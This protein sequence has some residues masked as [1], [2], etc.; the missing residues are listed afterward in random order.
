MVM[1]FIRGSDPLSGGDPLVG[2]EVSWLMG[3]PAKKS[4]FRL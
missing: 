4:G 2:K 3:S 1:R